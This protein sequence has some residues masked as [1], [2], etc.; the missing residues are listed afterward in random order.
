M[1][2]LGAAVAVLVAAVVA[3]VV[4]TSGSSGHRVPG[5]T[6]TPGRSDQAARYAPQQVEVV[7][8]QGTSVTLQWTDANNGQFPYVVRISGVPRLQVASSS[9]RTVVEG[10]TAGTPY[11]FE[12]GAV[13][14]VGLVSYAP[15]VCVNGGQVTPTSAS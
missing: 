4:S 15:Q 12:V 8:E 11:C 9:T 13:Y 3:V 14:A 5:T 10:L 7:S 2:G 6:V 1:A